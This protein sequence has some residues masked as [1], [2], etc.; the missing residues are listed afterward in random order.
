MP[1]AAEPVSPRDERRRPLLRCGE[2][3][4]SESAHTADGPSQN[5]LPAGRTDDHCPASFL[6]DARRE[7]DEL[8]R[9]NGDLARRLQKFQKQVIQLQRQAHAARCQKNQASLLSKDLQVSVKELQMELKR[10]NA[11]TQLLERH[12]SVATRGEKP[13]LPAELDVIVQTLD[14]MNTCHQDASALSMELSCRNS[15][16]REAAGARSRDVPPHGGTVNL[17]GHD[18]EISFAGVDERELPRAT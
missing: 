17:H 18:G 15:G 10:E 1:A 4:Y 13:S 9:E 5:M 16:N 12:L 8:K 6:A 2:P 3:G 14:G 11:R 7:R